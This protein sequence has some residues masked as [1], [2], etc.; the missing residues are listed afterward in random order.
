MLRKKTC[1]TCDA[2]FIK[3]KKV[4]C[5]VLHL[6]QDT[7]QYQYKLRDEWIERSPVEKNLEILVSK[8]IFMTWQCALAVQKSHILGCTKRSV[9]SKS[10]GVIRI[11][12]LPIVRHHPQYYVELWRTWTCWKTEESHKNRTLLL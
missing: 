12:L 10:R 4:T 1:N 2:N 8:K 9:T 11:T 7:H 3:F 5:K 6:S